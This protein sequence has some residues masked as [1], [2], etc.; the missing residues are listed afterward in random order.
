LVIGPQSRPTQAPKFSQLV[1][2]VRHLTNNRSKSCR[3]RTAISCCQ[4]TGGSQVMRHHSRTV[5]HWVQKESDHEN[6]K[7]PIPLQTTAFMTAVKES[8]CRTNLG[9][10]NRAWEKTLQGGHQRGSLSKLFSFQQSATCFSLL[11]KTTPQLG[12]RSMRGWAGKR[13]SWS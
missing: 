3:S 6:L 9:Q 8:I 11:A 10:T 13:K 5:C 7:Q 4:K 2:Q 1:S 12:F